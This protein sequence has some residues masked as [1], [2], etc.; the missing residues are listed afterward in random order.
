M[1]ENIGTSSDSTDCVLDWAAESI[2]IGNSGHTEQHD[3][4]MQI[5]WI[6]P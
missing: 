1:Q 4:E 2:Q 3:I 6:K 5:S